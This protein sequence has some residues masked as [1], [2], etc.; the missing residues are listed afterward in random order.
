MIRSKYYYIIQVVIV[1]VSV[2]DAIQSQSVQVA[3][4]APEVEGVRQA[5][6]QSLPDPEA[7]PL[8]LLTTQAACLWETPLPNAENDPA[9][10]YSTDSCTSI[11]PATQKCLPMVPSAADELDEVLHAQSAARRVSVDA[12]E[13][14]VWTVSPWVTEAP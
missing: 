5:L 9:S 6:T 4:D 10:L 11:A 12:T 2:D 1:F 3:P 14:M 7:V 13:G 8:T